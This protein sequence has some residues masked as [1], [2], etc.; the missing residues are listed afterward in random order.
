MIKTTVSCLCLVILLVISFG[1]LRADS[2]EIP[3]EAV[4]RTL[5]CN[6]CHKPEGKGVGISLSKIAK[7]Y[8]GQASRLNDYLAG[9]SEAMLNPAKA[10]IMARYIKK[11]KK[12][13]HAQRK[14]LTDY[15]L[16]FK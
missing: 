1:T 7:G 5:H 12:L 9:E 15:L 4:F 3:G 10:R 16:S 11:T 6:G 8:A 14:S 2:G 13:S